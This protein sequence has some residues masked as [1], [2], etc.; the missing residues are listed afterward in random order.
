LLERSLLE[1]I[2]ERR[3]VDAPTFF[4]IDIQPD[5][6]EGFVRLLRKAVPSAEPTVT[7]LVRSRL[8]AVNGQRVEPHQGEE[9]GSPDRQREN[10]YFTREYVLTFLADLPKDNAILRG[11]WWDR[12][13][14]LTPQVSVEEE[15]ARN[16]GL[17]LGSTVEF[18]IQGTTVTAVVGSIRK[19]DWSNFSTNFYMILSP[20]SLEGAPFTYVATARVAP[21][22][23]VPAQQ[24]V[25]RRFPNVT[26]I[27][28]G[29]VMENLARVLERLSI[30]IRAIALFCIVA[31]AVVMAAALVTTRRQRLYE[32]VILKAVGATRGIVAQ[33]FA[34]EYA[35]LGAIAGAVGAVLASLLA[36]VVL[37]YVL[38][39]SWKLQPSVLAVGVLLTIAL[40]VAV[41]FLGTFRIL[42]EPPLAVLRG[43]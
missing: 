15:A 7:P 23:E 12:S 30:A 35:L 27:N 5:Q 3:P 38:E 14:T 22:D 26:A 8:F 39:M 19:V 43:E 1:E 31:G 16:I 13:E 42:N 36:W 6:Q 41:G 37:A 21:G 28:L 4:F 10:W 33:A 40:T 29:D 34:A 17:D 2:G 24:A 25:V 18:D 9:T 11:R 32:S 20:G